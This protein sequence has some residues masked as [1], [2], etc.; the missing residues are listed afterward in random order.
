[1]A[2]VGAANFDLVTMR[3]VVGSVG[4]VFQTLVETEKVPAELIG[5]G[6][7]AFLTVWLSSF[8]LTL[9]GFNAGILSGALLV[10]IHTGLG[11]GIAVTRPCASRR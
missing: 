9:P 10:H 7:D 2:S 6:F 3:Q 1:M 11:V 4:H 5:H 8:P